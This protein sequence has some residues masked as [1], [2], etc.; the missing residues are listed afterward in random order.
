MMVYALSDASSGIRETSYKKPEVYSHMFDYLI[1]PNGRVAHLVPLV[2]VDFTTAC[3]KPALDWTN[4]AKAGTIICMNCLAALGA[5]SG[6]AKV[7]RK[8]ERMGSGR[9][10]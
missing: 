4:H 9:D 7:N 6:M 8:G 1:P 5:D 10:S 2:W 3:G